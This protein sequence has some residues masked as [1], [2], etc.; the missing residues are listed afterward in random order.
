MMRV[1]AAKVNLKQTKGGHGKDVFICW[2]F[3]IAIIILMLG[4]SVLFVV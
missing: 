3:H 1:I 4:L 2:G